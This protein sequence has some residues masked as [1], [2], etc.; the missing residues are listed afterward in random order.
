MASVRPFARATE[1]PRRRHTPGEGLLG[2]A[3]GEERHGRFQPGLID[4]GPH[5][6]RLGRVAHE[7]VAGERPEVRRDEAGD[8]REGTRSRGTWFAPTRRRKRRT[9]R[10]PRTPSRRPRSLRIPRVAATARPAVEWAEP[11]HRRVRLTPPRSRIRRCDPPAE[12]ATLESGDGGPCVHV[13]VATA[14]MLITTQR[15]GTR[16]WR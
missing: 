7:S 11:S 14:S 16:R 10:H 4:V 2:L 1:T 3:P 5:I 9:G 13:T 8:I 6:G 15:V 12:P